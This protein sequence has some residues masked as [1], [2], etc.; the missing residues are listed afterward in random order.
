MATPVIYFDEELQEQLEE[1]EAIEAELSRRSLKRFV[2][3]TWH[4][5]EPDQELLWNWHLDEICDVLEAVTRGEI[6]RVIL[7]VPPGTMKSLIVSVFWPAW[8]WATNPGLRYLCASYSS[9]LSI[10]DNMRLRTIVR[11]SWYRK[12]F[13]LALSSDQNA[14]ERF[15]TQQGG[16]RI[17]TSVGGVG[18]GEH[19][20]RIVIDDPVSAAQARSE[21]ERKSA[22][23]WLDSTMSTRGV[24]RDVAIV[25]VMQRLHEDDPTAHLQAKGSW[26]VIVF[27]MRYDPARKDPLDRREEAGELLWPELFPES[28]VRQLEIDLGP[29][30]AAGQLQQ[31]PAPQG[32]GLFKREWFKLV[33]ALPAIAI[34]VRGWDTAGTEADGDYTV[35]VKISYDGR[36]FYVEDVQRDRLAPAGVDALMRAVAATDGKHVAVREEKEPGSAGVSVIEAHTRMLIGWDYKGV[37]TTGDKMTRAKPFR[38]QCEAGNVVLLRAAWNDAYLGELCIFPNGKHDDQVDA[39]SCAFNEVA[40]VIPAARV[41][42][43]SF[44]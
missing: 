6:K 20:D 2:Y 40:N 32:G 23:D 34:R 37:P 29:Y 1:L 33:D 24:A 38:A 8:E 22:N 18:T 4:L 25:V 21:V 41:G 10:R 35:G 12:H 16:W 26:R 43:T 28:K 39:S 30:D 19:P 9:G 13:D 31:L 27:P 15:T 7:N 3:E 44:A 11:S 36:K 5:V 14:K 42:T 17:A